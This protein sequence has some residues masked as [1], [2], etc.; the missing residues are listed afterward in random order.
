M[1]NKLLKYILLFLM[2][3]L[4]SGIYSCSG[5]SRSGIR[6]TSENNRR[7]STRSNTVKPPENKRSRSTSTNRPSTKEAPKSESFANGTSVSEM[8]EKLEKGVFIVYARDYSGGAQGSGFFINSKGIGITN[9]NVLDGFNDYQI[10]MS[11]GKSYRITEILETSTPN[12]YDYVIFKVDNQG[13]RFKSMKIAKS[14]SK[15]GEDIFT[16][17]SPRGLEN[18]LSTGILSGYR[19]NSR[20]QIDATI[21][22]G[23]SGGPLFNM[24]GEVIGITTSK[25]EG[26]ALNFAVDI[27]KVPYKKYL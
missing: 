11:N 23:S 17:G 10:K 25:I 3:V 26:A 15:I 13:D 14:K 18:S 4:L 16:I 19:N 6:H 21:D 24:K 7:S 20:I 2:V 12:N 5:C 22:H 9:Y 27:R 1:I 8:F